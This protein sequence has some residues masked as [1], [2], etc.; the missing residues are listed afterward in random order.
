MNFDIVKQEIPLRQVCASYG[1]KLKKVGDSFIACCPFHTEN[2]PSFRVFPD[3]HFHCFGCG[4]H[5]TILDF[6]MLTEHCDLYEA[7]RKLCEKFNPSLL[8][9]DDDA[10]AKAMKYRREQEN[11]T[12]L[13]EKNA[14]VA[15]VYNL[16]NR[17]H[18]EGND[19]T[20]QNYNSAVLNDTL[21]C[22]EMYSLLFFNDEKE[23][24][25]RILYEY[26][27]ELKEEPK[28]GRGRPTKEALTSQNFAEWLDLHDYSLRLN[29][30]TH[31]VE[32]EGIPA[33]KCPPERLNE[34]LEVI[35]YDE[36]KTEYSCNMNLI[37][38]LVK[39]TADRN[40]FNPVQE[41]LDSIPEWDGRDR[42]EEIYNALHIPQDDSLSR[43]LI[44]K[45]CI[46]ALSLQKNGLQGN[47][48][49]A[50]GALVLDGEQGYGK[51][52]FC[53]FLSMANLYPVAYGLFKEGIQLTS[54]KD[55]EIAATSAWIVELGELGGTTS[56]KDRDALKVFI[57]R[58]MDEIR[59]H[60]GRKAVSN[61]RRSVFIG[62]VNDQ[63]FLN[64]PTGSRR[65]W[66]VDIT[67]P[68]DFETLDHMDVKQLWKQIQKYSDED[69][70]S[71]RLT[72]EERESVQ[73][74]N[75]IYEKPIPAEDEINDIFAKV[76]AAPQD[77][78][79][80]WITT[81]DF[82]HYY[83]RLAKYSGVVIGRALKKIMSK[84]NCDTAERFEKQSENSEA[85]ARHKYLPVPKN[86][87]V[88]GSPSEIPPEDRATF[89]VSALRI[90]Q[91]GLSQ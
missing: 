4:T 63:T 53:R 46:M 29:L 18:I 77:F 54:D 30:I 76:F 44:R 17:L 60:Y 2:T 28:R 72:P 40:A 67:Q 64:D 52:R 49:G 37:F 82:A 90:T 38:D 78:K 86:A 41:I 3:N 34:N 36:L 20:A 66:V 42:L 33:D 50:D 75:G 85:R 91:E 23:T 10:I 32:V 45:F 73:R 8:D 55:S 84:Y 88:Y 13:E 56:K 35:L 31:R 12:A 26:H 70:H 11:R 25:D 48:F 47:P 79:W 89:A 69:I 83:D 9:A 61:Y 21:S 24:A 14:L 16:C 15:A 59:P 39:L 71:F 65:W 62:T 87:F 5:G 80:C 22:D 1:L 6:V 74:R 57:T 7:A 68:I 81:S 51:T 19:N 43:I 58:E 27:P